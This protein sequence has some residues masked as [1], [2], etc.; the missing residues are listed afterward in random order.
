MQ[1]D[2][3][4][5]PIRG[6]RIS[7]PWFDP[8]PPRRATPFDPTAQQRAPFEAQQPR[9][10][11]PAEPPRNAQRPYV[12]PPQREPTP[13][14][15]PTPPGGREAHAA[16]PTAP[17][18]TTPAP[19]IAA[20]RADVDQRSDGSAPRSVDR[21]DLRRALADLEAA[22]ERVAREGKRTEEA[23]R[24]RLVGELLPV[25]DD[26][27][28]TI[29]SG[30]SDEGLLHGVELVRQRLERVL[31]GYGLERIV[32][33]NE[34]FDPAQHEAIAIAP[35]TEPA[36]HGLIVDEV[37]RGYRLGDRV[38]R[39]ARVRVGQLVAA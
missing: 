35:V 25:L 6:A 15:A 3:W 17:S 14:R 31:A 18:P 36:L 23:A 33:L 4:G 30:S 12:E 1:R 8:P 32:T 22:K 5:R 19:P 28:R 10:T 29:A 39:P 21:P 9:Q 27:D 11:P 2:P 20:P 13:F 37:A 16:E 34:R 24:L 7:N 26:L 38:Q